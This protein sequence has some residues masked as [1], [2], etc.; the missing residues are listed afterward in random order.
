MMV[1]KLKFSTSQTKVLLY[2]FHFL[3]SKLLFEFDA[4][5]SKIICVIFFTWETLIVALGLT[6]FYLSSPC[7][8]ADFAMV[9]FTN[10]ELCLNLKES[11][12]CP[13]SVITV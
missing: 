9:S 10:G 5:M 11:F 2:F 6:V 12:F 3:F 13:A 7:R 4:R 1:T 8:T